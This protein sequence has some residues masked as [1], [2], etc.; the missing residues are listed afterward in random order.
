MI[1]LATDCSWFFFGST[2][3]VYRKQLY[4]Y[5]PLQFEVELIRQLNSMLANIRFVIRITITINAIE[6]LIECT[7]TFVLNY[8]F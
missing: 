2:F 5:I 8:I 1:S 4:F 3:S 6:I 7:T